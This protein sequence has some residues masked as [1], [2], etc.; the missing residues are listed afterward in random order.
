V[1]PEDGKII[2]IVTRTDLL[3]LIGGGDT[4][5][6]EHNNLSQRLSEALPPVRLELLR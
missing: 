6:S 5:I 1:Q 4:T 3:K 2:G